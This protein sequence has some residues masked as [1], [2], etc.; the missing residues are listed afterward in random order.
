MNYLGVVK[1]VRD[2]PTHPLRV[3]VDLGG[4][5]LEVGWLS[6]AVDAWAALKRSAIVPGL[7]VMVWQVPYAAHPDRYRVVA[8]FPA[9]DSPLPDTTRALARQG[10][11]VA[12]SGA[13][14]ITQAAAPTLLTG[15]PPVFPLGHD[16][17]GR[18]LED[19][20]DPEVSP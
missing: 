10:D 14:K 17:R 3:D 2:H 8:I 9:P 4:E 7:E 13:P 6:V 15:V 1:E 18:I 5:L 20:D 19:P 12:I 11:A 16:L